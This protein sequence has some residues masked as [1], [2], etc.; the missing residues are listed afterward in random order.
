MQYVEQLREELKQAEAALA[1]QKLKNEAEA[2]GENEA[3]EARQE[4]AVPASTEDIA[5]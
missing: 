5:G 3:V 4:E 1:E 2:V